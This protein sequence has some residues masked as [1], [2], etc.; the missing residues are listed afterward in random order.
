MRFFFVCACATLSVALSAQ[1][2]IHWKHYSANNG[3]SQNNVQ[4]FVQGDNGYIW[5]SS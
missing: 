2:L 5:M 4:G 3:L 1:S